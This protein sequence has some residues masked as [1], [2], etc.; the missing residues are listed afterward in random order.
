MTAAA[1]I[2]RPAG[3][4]KRSARLRKPGAIRSAFGAR[5]RKKAGTPMLNVEMTVR[6]RG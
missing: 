5:A 4:A 6:C 3:T 1:A 2:T